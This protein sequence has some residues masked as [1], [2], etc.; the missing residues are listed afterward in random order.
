MKDRPSGAVY[1]LAPPLSRRALLHR[2]DRGDGTRHHRAVGLCP[3]PAHGRDERG[4]ARDYRP[5]SVDELIG[6]QL[7]GRVGH[8]VPSVHQQDLLHPTHVE[9]ETHG[10]PP[11]VRSVLLA[12]MAAIMG[13][14]SQT[15]LIVTDVPAG[16]PWTRT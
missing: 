7:E 15:T 5:P 13:A 1:F 11:R 16:S 9:R 2:Q 14:F 3:P 12:E 10:H 8:P 4:L 6:V